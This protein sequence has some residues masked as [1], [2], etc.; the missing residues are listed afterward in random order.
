MWLTYAVAMAL[1]KNRTNNW[2][3]IHRSFMFTI[4]STSL[5]VSRQVQIVYIQFI[6]PQINTIRG[7]LFEARLA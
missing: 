5:S 6:L 2:R 3:Y 7:R 1:L 4:Y